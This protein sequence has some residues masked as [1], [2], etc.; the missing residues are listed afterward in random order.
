MKRERGGLLANQSPTETHLTKM[1]LLSS[2]F[3][4]FD[5][6]DDSPIPFNRDEEWKTLS[7]R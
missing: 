5:G 3:F 6:L 4:I 2:T 7:R 1:P